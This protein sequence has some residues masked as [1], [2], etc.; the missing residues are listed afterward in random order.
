[1]KDHGGEAPGVLTLTE[2]RVG[3]RKA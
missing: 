1:V 2:T 3:L